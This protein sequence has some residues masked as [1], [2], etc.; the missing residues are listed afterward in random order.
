MIAEDTAV[1]R[2]LALEEHDVVGQIY[3][4][5]R[6]IGFALEIVDLCRP[7]ADINGWEHHAAATLQESALI[8]RYVDDDRRLNDRV[9][10]Q[11]IVT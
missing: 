3:R 4:Q 8:G 10:D 5:M 2:T 6:R 7:P 9:Q 1:E 11:V